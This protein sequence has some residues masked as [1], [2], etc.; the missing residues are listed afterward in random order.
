MEL[1]QVIQE[2]ING[3][4]QVAEERS[5][6]RCM[7]RLTGG[8]LAGNQAGMRAVEMVREQRVVL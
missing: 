7:A 6:E 3:M 8:R 1:N 4:R 2:T 5:V